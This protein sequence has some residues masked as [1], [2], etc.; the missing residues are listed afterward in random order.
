MP[1]ITKASIEQDIAIRTFVESVT[2]I[3]LLPHPS[4][5]LKQIGKTIDVFDITKKQP[6]VAGPLRRYRDGIKR[7]DWDVTHATSRGDRAEF[8]QQLVKSWNIKS[9]VAGAITAREYGFTPFEVNWAVVDGKT[10][11]ISIKQR[12]RKWF[13]ADSNG[14]WRL[15]KTDTPNGILLEEKWPRKFI[16]VTHEATDENPYGEGILDELYWYAK[17][18]TF[19]FEQWLGFIEDDGRDRWVGWVPTGSDKAY[20]DKVEAAL[21]RLRNAAVGVIEEGTRVEKVENKGRTS[22]SEAYE[23]LKQSC[24]QTINVL[25][26][27]SDLSVNKSVTGARASS[28]SGLSIEESA[29]DAGK[30]LAEGIINTIFRHISELNALPGSDEEQIEFELLK[31][32]DKKQQAEIDKTYS[33][34]TGKRP[35]SQLMARRGYEEGDWED[36]PGTTAP[37]IPAITFESSGSKAFADML[38]ACTALKKKP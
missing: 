25:I 6:D 13:K 34:A 9:L 16:I 4:K 33:E 12:P 37:A 24:R 28:E 14:Q 5:V 26:L 10:V 7:L 35:S 29:L 17:A 1:D 11:P 3:G 22:S 36:T 27:G 15:I 8:F 30:E 31:P 18:L 38:D 23:L 32:I 20:K 21:L 19:D 2:T